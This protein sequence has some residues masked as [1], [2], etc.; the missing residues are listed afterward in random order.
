MRECLYESRY[1]KILLGKNG[2]MIKKIRENT[3][4]KISIIL[5]RKILNRVCNI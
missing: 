5:N 1:K 2:Q 4:K 3:Q